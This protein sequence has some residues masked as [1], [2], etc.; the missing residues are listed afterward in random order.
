MLETG[1]TVVTSRNFSDHSTL[2][3]EVRLLRELGDCSG[4]A[5]GE[6]TRSFLLVHVSAVKDANKTFQEEVI[7]LAAFMLLVS[8]KGSRHRKSR[9]ILFSH[10][11]NKNFLVPLI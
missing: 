10:D 1:F 4:G 8:M 9:E 7:N 5:G 6:S 2:G 11:L 3:E